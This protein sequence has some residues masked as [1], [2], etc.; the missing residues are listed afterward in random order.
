MCGRYA[1]NLPHETMRGVFGVHGEIPDFPPRYHIA[2]GVDI[3]VI[4][5]EDGERRVALLRWGIVPR[6][7]RDAVKPLINARSETVDSKPVFRDAFRLRRCIVPATGFYEWQAAPKGPKQPFHI[8]A[9]G[10]VP[11]AMAAL[12]EP[13]LATQGINHDSVTIITCEAN[14]LLRPLHERMPVILP[15]RVWA[16]WLD[17]ALAP[18]EAKSF[19]RPAPDGMLEAYPVGYGVNR[20]SNDGPELAMPLARMERPPPPQR[21]LS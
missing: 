6:W 2:P 21:D 12:W 3:L 11:F 5:L 16:N 18:A 10:G 20:A 1:A 17:P 9:R 8:R 14:G 13:S 19:L 15:E 4:R 7:T